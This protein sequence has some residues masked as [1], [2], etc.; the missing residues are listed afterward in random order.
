MHRGPFFWKP[1]ITQSKGVRIFQYCAE[2]FEGSEIG[3]LVLFDAV[4]IQ[5]NLT[6]ARG[7]AISKQMLLPHDVVLPGA[8][9][10]C[11]AEADKQRAHED[12]QLK[13]FNINVSTVAASTSTNKN[14]QKT[15]NLR[16]TDGKVAAAVAGK[17]RAKTHRPLP[18]HTLTHLSIITTSP[19]LPQLTQWLNQ[20]RATNT[21]PTTC[22]R[23]HRSH[24]R[25]R[26]TTR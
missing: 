18:L 9:S 6:L 19:T 24:R 5:R 25:R 20:S 16:R 3:L 26:A 17:T 21:S 10:P 22:R 23:C 2:I 7:A 8:S 1:I 11:A 12:F 4:G 14:A 13:A 15:N